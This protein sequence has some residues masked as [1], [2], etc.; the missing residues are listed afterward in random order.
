[1]TRPTRRTL[2]AIAG[3]ALAVLL[4]GC[5]SATTANPKIAS[6]TFTSPAIKGT[7]IPALY[8]CDGKNIWPSFEWSAV[9]AGTRELVLLAVGLKP[10]SESGSYNVSVEWALAGINPALRRL[11]AGRLPRGAY[12]GTNSAGKRTYSICPERGVSENY[13]FQLYAVP[14][15]LKVAHEFIGMSVLGPLSQ[16]N[17]SQSATAQGALVATYKRS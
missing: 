8:T 4:A 14:P 6:L 11:E 13:Q 7:A 17:T 1:M 10:S 5:G 3:A 9:P 12:V 16:P 15:R 2:A